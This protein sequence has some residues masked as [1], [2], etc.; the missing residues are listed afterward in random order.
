MRFLIEVIFMGSRRPGSSRRCRAASKEVSGGLGK[1]RAPERWP[2]SSGRGLDDEFQV[3][4]FSV[5]S[6]FF[7]FV[8][9]GVQ[10]GPGGVELH[11]RRSQEVPG[12]PLGRRVL[13][14]LVRAGGSDFRQNS[15]PSFGGR[16]VRLLAR[17]RTKQAESPKHA[18][19]Y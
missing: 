7:L 15:R 1:P 13:R 10:V 2:E 17:A 9:W 11:P 12:L 6:G 3:E 4:G 8:F 19:S 5:E 16:V 14:F 18:F